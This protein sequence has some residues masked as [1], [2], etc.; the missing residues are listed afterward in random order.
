MVSPSDLGE[1][2]CSSHHHVASQY[3]NMIDEHIL[4][5]YMISYNKKDISRFQD[6]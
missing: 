5:N 4:V 1:Y 3:L 2:N 6:P